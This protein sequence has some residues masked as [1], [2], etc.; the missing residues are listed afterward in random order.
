MKRSY[1]LK[2]LILSVFS[3]FLICCNNIDSSSGLEEAKKAIS[4]S[5][6]IYFEAYEKND[7]SIFTD[8]YAND[9]CIMAP[10]K[11]EFC[12]KQQAEKF[13]RSSYDN[14]GLRG[15]RFITTAVYGDGKVYVTE[16]GVW[17]SVNAKR[18]LFDHGKFL[19]LWK[20]TPEGW[21]MFKDSFSADQDPARATGN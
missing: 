18:Q 17:Q 4:A 13:F 6:A 7:P 8:R 14:Y 21:K 15:G 2:S 19:V 16:E 10:G 20:K 1:Y 12:G 3:F 9:V 5:N 11:P